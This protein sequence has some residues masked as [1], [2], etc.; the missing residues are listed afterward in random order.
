MKKKLQTH[1][2]RHRARSGFTLV[3]LI[4]YVAISA[5]VL[6]TV[7]NFAWSIIDTKTYV[8][9]SAEITQNGRLVLEQLTRDI[10]EAESI[11]DSTSIFDTH[12]GTLTLQKGDDEIIIDTYSHPLTIGGKTITART[13]RRRIN[14]ENDE[15]LT[16]NIVNVSNF[17]IQDLSANESSQN[18]N[19]EIT[20]E[21]INPGNDQTRD[22]EITIESS[23]TLRKYE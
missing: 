13:L 12:P 21:Y 1:T 14:L 11:K 16:S 6:T 17:V 10:R 22:K 19:F 7:L 23:A 15:D 20:L 3:E 18:I 8:N 9:T 4:I 2:S 5:I